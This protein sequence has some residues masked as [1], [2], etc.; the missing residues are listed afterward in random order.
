MTKPKNFKIG[1]FIQIKHPVNKLDF[2]V[3]KVS[4]IDLD[5]VLIECL[6]DL[7][8]KKWEKLSYANWILA[9]PKEIARILAVKLKS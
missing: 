4:D 6:I 8:Y 9:S 2:Y 7:N 3:Y 1:D 5:K